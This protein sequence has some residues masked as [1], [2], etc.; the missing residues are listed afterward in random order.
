MTTAAEGMIRFEVKNGEEIVASGTLYI[1]GNPADAA[2][3]LWAHA[4]TCTLVGTGLR[5]EQDDRNGGGIIRFWE[6][7][8]YDLRG[9]AVTLS[10]EELESSVFY[11]NSTRITVRLSGE[12]ASGTVVLKDRTQGGAEIGYLE[13][14][15]GKTEGV[16][17]ALSAARRY[18]LLW[19]GSEDC[20]I[21]VGS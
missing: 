13:L 20:A 15:N 16:F 11:T 12:T 6:D 19:T 8:L 2:E 14:G 4:Y 5:L 18:Q 1:T 17:T 7:R 9:G 3:P 21:T 10:A